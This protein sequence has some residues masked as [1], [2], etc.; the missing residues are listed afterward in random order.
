ML[1]N[2]WTF[3]LTSLV[4]ILALAFVAPSAMAG[5]FGVSLS[6]GSDVDVSS[7]GEIQVE[8]GADVTDTTNADTE[9]IIMIRTDKV[10]DLQPAGTNAGGQS[11]TD[12]GDA[13]NGT[14]PKPSGIRI[15]K[16][17]F[18][19]IAYNEFGGTV[20][21]P[22]LGDVMAID[23]PDGK[24]FQ[25]TLTLTDVTPQPVTRVLVFLAK[26]KIELADPRAEL[27]GTTRKADGMSAEASLTIHYVNAEPAAPGNMPRVLSIRRAAD[28]L[29]PITGATADV[30]ILLSEKPHEFKKAQVDVTNAAWG[31]PVALEPLPEDADGPDNTPGDPDAGTPPNLTPAEER[32]RAHAADNMPS[33]GR[34]GMVYPYVLTITP[35]YKNMDDIVVKVKAFSDQVLPSTDTNDYTPHTREA[36]YTEGED[37][38]TIKVGKDDPPPKTAGIRIAI[39]EK[40][41]VA[42]SGYLVVAKDDADGDDNHDK[43]TDST[44]VEYAGDPT[45]DPAVTTVRAPNLQTYNIIKAGLPNLETFLANGGVI[46]VVSPHA[47]LIISEVMWGSDASLGSGNA[48]LDPTDNQWIELYN[49]GAKYTTVK[50]DD[51]T[52]ALE[53]TYLVFYRPNETP[54]AKTAAVA[55]TATTAA[56]PAALPAGVTDRIGTITDAG[57]YWSIAGKGQSGRTGQGEFAT[58]LVAVIPTQPV[59]SMY[60]VMVPSTAAGAAAGAMMP[61]YGNTSAAWMASTPPA[62]NFR[63]GAVGVRI[64]SPGAG[65][66]VTAAETAAAEAA[67][68]AKADAAAAAAA[69]ASDTSVSMPKVGQIYIS[70]LMVAGGGTLPQWIEISNGSRS[71]QVNLSGWTLTVNNAAADADVSVSSITLTIPEGTKIDPS[72]QHDTPSTILVVTEQGR[73]NLSGADAAGQV[74]NLWDS[75]QT[76]LILGGITKRRYALL[77]DMAFQITLAPPVPI[78]VPAAATPA[79]TTAAEIAAKRAADAAK[80]VADAKEAA[81]RVAATD[82]VGNLGAD[83]AAAWALP[84]DDSGARSSILRSHVQVSVGPAEPE[85]GMM[86]DSWGLASETSFAQVT[87]IRASSYY[88]A[89]NDVGTPGFRAGGA[90]PVELSHFRPARQETGAV[91]IT[92]S[93]QSELNNAG[94]FIKRSQQRDGEFKVINATMV[95]G[96]GTSSE[97]QFY[98]YTDAT[99]QPNVVYYY[100]IEDVSLDG[101]RQT[102]TRGIRLKGHVGAAGKATTTWGDLKTQE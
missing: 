67:A 58:D 52:A 17:D 60:R 45:K 23:A 12:D 39:P 77:S 73:N 62:V 49:P 31:D 51:A 83:G 20:T 3:S 21:A 86:M 79:P 50:E 28:P 29:I 10:V 34:D 63:S 1:S 6:V 47:G 14:E 7:E 24:H 71:E 96:A 26:H 72:G 76:E 82:T 4:I 68:K 101:N 81:A 75:N 99:A 84:M 85:D 80:K 33:T 69:K 74:L 91:V 57:A 37:K 18:E 78:V 90:L 13:D 16:D 15:G 30:I 2:K 102:L 53:A 59:V 64:G 92:W 41:V 38:L 22:T 9:V 46:D 35:T 48:K 40:I 70:E 55:A 27:D 88:G 42:A 56:V 5:E 65:R 25:A 19:I 100:Q 89:A 66:L 95:P 44:Q 98:T 11:E 43:R 87:H 94:F 8:Y 32:L 93:T 54:P 97:K 61:A 36:D